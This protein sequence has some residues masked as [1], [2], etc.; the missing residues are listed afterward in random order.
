MKA[1]KQANGA[2]LEHIA[3][4]AGRVPPR[5][6]FDRALLE[7]LT[8][9]A[10]DGRD[11]LRDGRRAAMIRALDWRATWSQIREWRRGRVRAPEWARDM[12]REKIAARR[13]RFEHAEKLLEAS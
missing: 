9:E 5:T 3:S 4:P 12:I 1:L 10:R 13:Q 6:P 11:G 8:L 2:R 7:L